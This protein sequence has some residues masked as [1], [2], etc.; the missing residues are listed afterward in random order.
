MLDDG[1]MMDV[2]VTNH[3]GPSLTGALGGGG[4]GGGSVSCCGGG[5]GSISQTMEDLASPWPAC[6]HVRLGA[7]SRLS[8]CQDRLVSWVHLRPWLPVK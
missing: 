2:R 8:V 7:E 4:G 1:W 5:G 6:S 3:H